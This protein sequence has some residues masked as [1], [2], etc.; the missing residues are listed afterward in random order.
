MTGLTVEKLN[1]YKDQIKIILR[2]SFNLVAPFYVSVAKFVNDLVSVQGKRSKRLNVL[3]LKSGSD[4]YNHFGFDGRHNIYPLA[5]YERVY[6]VEEKLTGIRQEAYDNLVRLVTLN[7]LSKFT[8]EQEWYDEFKRNIKNLSYLID[9]GSEE[10]I[11]GFGMGNDDTPIIYDKDTLKNKAENAYYS[12]SPMGHRCYLEVE[13]NF[14]LTIEACTAEKKEE[15]SMEK[16]NDFLKILSFYYDL[17]FIRITYLSFSLETI[18]LY[19][20][21]YK[22]DSYPFMKISHSDGYYGTFFCHRTGSEY[23]VLRRYN[24]LIFNYEGPPGVHRFLF[25]CVDICKD[26]VKKR[27]KALNNIVDMYI[28][29]P[30]ESNK[31]QFHFDDKDELKRER[32]L[33]EVG[34]IIE[35]FLGQEHPGPYLQYVFSDEIFIE[36]LAFTKERK[37]VERLLQQKGYG[38]DSIIHYSY[39]FALERKNSYSK[40]INSIPSEMGDIFEISLFMKTDEEKDESLTQALKDLNDKT[41]YLDFRLSPLMGSIFKSNNK[42]MPVDPYTYLH[43]DKG[44]GLMLSEGEISIRRGDPEVDMN[45]LIKRDKSKSDEVN[46]GISKLYSQLDSALSRFCYLICLRAA[47]EKE[48][49]GISEDSLI[50][51]ILSQKTFLDGVYDDDTLLVPDDTIS[52]EILANFFSSQ[53]DTNALF[54]EIRLR[55]DKVRNKVFIGQGNGDWEIRSEK[56]LAFVMSEAFDADEQ[57]TLKITRR[58][59]SSGSYDL[60]L[61]FHSP[62]MSIEDVVSIESEGDEIFIDRDKLKVFPNFSKNG[63][64]SFVIRLNGAITIGARIGNELPKKLSDVRTYTIKELKDNCLPFN[65]IY[66]RGFSKDLSL[67]Y[68][69]KHIILYRKYILSKVCAEIRKELDDR[70]FLYS[71]LFVNVEPINLDR[72]LDDDSFAEMLANFLHDYPCY[73]KNPY[74]LYVKKNMDLESCFGDKICDPGGGTSMF[75]IIENKFDSNEDIESKYDRLFD[76]FMRDTYIEVFRR[77]LRLYI[78]LRDDSDDNA[79]KEEVLKDVLL[80]SFRNNNGLYNANKDKI[81]FDKLGIDSSG[82]MSERRS[83]LYPELENPSSFDDDAVSGLIE[84]LETATEEDVNIHFFFDSEYGDKYKECLPVCLIKLISD[85]NKGS[86]PEILH[87]CYHSFIKE[88]NR[89]K[90]NEK[91]MESVSDTIFKFYSVNMR[92]FVDKFGSEIN[93]IKE[94]LMRKKGRGDIQNKIKVYNDLLR[95]IL[96]YKLGKS[97]FSELESCSSKVCFDREGV[98]DYKY[99]DSPINPD[100]VNRVFER[101]IRGE[102]PID[103]EV[104]LVDGGYI[105]VDDN[106]DC[107]NIFLITIDILEEYFKNIGGEKKINYIRFQKGE[108]RGSGVFKSELNRIL[109]YLDDGSTNR[110]AELERKVGAEAVDKLYH[111]LG[112]LIGVYRVVLEYFPFSKKLKS[113]IEVAFNP[114]ITK[115]SKHKSLFSGIHKILNIGESSYRYVLN[116]SYP[117]SER[118]I[119]LI[120]EKYNGSPGSNLGDSDIKKYAEVIKGCIRLMNRLQI[121]NFVFNATSSYTPLEIHVQFYRLE[122]ERHSGGNTSDEWKRKAYFNFITCARTL[123]ID[124]GV[125]ESCDYLQLACELSL[126]TGEDDFNNA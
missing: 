6:L 53:L 3:E 81:V 25:N 36:F 95:L 76:F 111:K 18:E 39:M 124:V 114:Y 74:L 99:R 15:Y 86:K 66:Y 63:K 52:T 5:F 7:E 32:K 79:K 82:F 89:D 1:E 43:G 97:N 119:E 65:F 101:I 27:I 24:S 42:G 85:E 14:K 68:M 21:V 70:L 113:E 10:D 60:F 106:I 72:K 115:E 93:D 112:V 116:C 29:E 73:T 51:E 122:E 48:C 84:R 2:N 102:S 117:N 49:T 110:L 92:E 94:Y 80:C 37:K 61:V 96:F 98:S 108:A 11:R 123:K 13:Q 50:N 19:Y 55:S 75:F 109:E 71:I 104:E 9:I 17:Y 107:D 30:N 4:I 90:T 118:V 35:D 77:V 121:I 31:R 62:Y 28:L 54:R 78:S 44:K 87:G 69:E 100:I 120:G 46:L 45:Y 83:V 8:F 41:T 23:S 38:G 64:F 105:K 12:E 40:L 56:D 47:I 103:Q 67:F 26:S 125:L 33:K 34:S 88:W 20:K 59:S 16:P 91:K 58:G 57:K 126:E 22:T